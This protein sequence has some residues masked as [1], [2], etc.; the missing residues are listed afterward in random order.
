MKIGEAN[1]GSVSKIIGE[2][3]P[4]SVWRFNRRD[5][6]MIPVAFGG[7]ATDNI[8]ANDVAQRSPYK[9]I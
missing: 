2:L 6:Q 3:Q 5:G 8:S 1:Q 4:I 9:D 7:T